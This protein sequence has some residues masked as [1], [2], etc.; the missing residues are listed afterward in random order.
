MKGTYLCPHCRGAINVGNNIILSARSCTKQVGL[1]R[2]HEEL[3]N[4]TCDL[5]STLALKEGDVVD[6]FCPVCHES[7]NQSKKDVLAK[8]I[9]IDDTCNEFTIIIS[10]RY[11]EKFT[12][13]VDEKNHVK[14]YG[15]KISR[16]I[17]PEWFL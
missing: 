4:Y 5:S 6:L 17:D 13:R 14:T 8:F 16:F 11:G 1:I 3:G 9:M 7:L 10:R 12:F 15:E 2:M